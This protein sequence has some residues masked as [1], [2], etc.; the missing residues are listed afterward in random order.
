M[1][2]LLWEN[3]K[4][5]RL[6]YLYS[7]LSV[8]LGILCQYYFPLSY[9]Y[10]ITMVVTLLILL[11]EINRLSKISNSGYFYFLNKLPI[12]RVDIY[13]HK[14]FVSTSGIFIIFLFIIIMNFLPFCLCTLIHDL[15]FYSNMMLAFII[16]NNTTN[17]NNSPNKLS[18]QVSKFDFYVAFGFLFAYF[19]LL[20]EFITS[21][22]CQIFGQR[23]IS[24]NYLICLIVQFVSSYYLSLIYYR[25]ITK[26]NFYKK[27]QYDVDLKIQV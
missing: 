24:I 8:S 2:K 1:K 4:L 25:R 23:F 16:T 17:M 11:P 22:Y 7:L 14:F 21:D 6:N 13:R 18:D 19:I 3:L 27:N 15:R 12:S 20:F 5:F 9:N 10:Y 26:T